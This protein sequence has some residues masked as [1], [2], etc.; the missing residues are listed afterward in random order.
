MHKSNSLDLY[1]KNDDN[2]GPR[3]NGV[4]YK[5]GVSL[6]TIGQFWLVA[7]VGQK[8][9]VAIWNLFHDVFGPLLAPIPTFIQFGQKTQ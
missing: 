7:P 9:V 1:E 3:R 2:Y 6:V 5:M 4:V 8:V